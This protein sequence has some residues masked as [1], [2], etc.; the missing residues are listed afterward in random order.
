MLRMKALPNAFL[1]NSLFEIDRF[2]SVSQT[3]KISSLQLFISSQSNSIPAIEKS[4]RTIRSIS[5]PS[6]EPLR[7]LSNTLKAQSSF[8]SGLLLVWLELIAFNYRNTDGVGFQVSSPSCTPGNPSFHFY[9]RQTCWRS[10][11]IVGWLGDRTVSERIPWIFSIGNCQ[12]GK[13]LI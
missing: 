4:P 9:P 7:S 12:Y 11:L 1:R 3:R 8:S 5:P 10:P 6:M 2:P 13:I